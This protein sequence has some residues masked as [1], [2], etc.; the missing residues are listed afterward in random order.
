MNPAV[1]MPNLCGDHAC[2]FG[3]VVGNCLR[4]L[5][6]MT[7]VTTAS[8]AIAQSPSVNAPS[9]NEEA[10]A[11]ASSAGAQQ[12]AQDTFSGPTE[13][14]SRLQQAEVIRVQE[15]A[16]FPSSPLW[17]LRRV[18]DSTKQHLYETTCIK[19]GVLLTDVF[20]GVSDAIDDQDQLG[21]ATT[22]I[23]IAK[24][25]LL[26][27]GEPEEGALWAQLES[28]WDYGSTGP[29]ELG[30]SSIGSAIGTADTFA[31]YDVAF[32]LRNLYWR[33]GSLDA[34]WVYRIGKISPDAM[35]AQSEYLDPL[36]T[37]L[38]S[39]GTGPFAIA[40]PDS[41]LGIAG[42][43]HL[44]DRVVLGGLVSDANGNRFDF[45]DLGAGDYFKAIELQAKIAPRTAEAPYS[46]VTFWHTDGTQDGQ[47]L[48]GQLGPEGWGFYIVH[49]QELTCDGRAIGVLRYGQSFGGSAA[50]ERQAGAHFLLNEPRIF[51]RFKSDAIG[52]AFNWAKLPV[53]GTRDEY[54]F[55]V[56][57][58]FPLFPE[59]DTTFS[60]QS[61]FNPALTRDID[62]ASVFSLRL[63]T[64]F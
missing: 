63:R 23:G 58:R 50:Y 20:Q 1:F 36:S 44:T 41:G 17:R 26:N 32:V 12:S 14:V 9:Y 61:V 28:R 64:V 35:L 57:Y 19:T 52:T 33:Q 39:G 49:Q 15:D 51:S 37:F 2:W 48:N 10:A 31:R 3:P 60:Y 53:P 16:L 5:A 42:G 43:V 29:E 18:T 47:P 21:N 25:E 13:P 22:F 4:A 40:L 56:F 59:V 6:L 11:R 54:H 62:H 34:N 27:R 46:K 30:A 7:L 38:P 45:G 8:S 24:W 55:E